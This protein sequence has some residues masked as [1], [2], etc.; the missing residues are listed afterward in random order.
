MRSSS[1]GKWLPSDESHR[2][3]VLRSGRGSSESAAARREML[4]P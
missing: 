3:T 1:R 2:V 4:P